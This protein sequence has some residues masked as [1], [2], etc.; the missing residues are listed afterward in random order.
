MNAIATQTALNMVP[1]YGQ[2]VTL[3]E[4]VE[5]EALGYGAWGNEMGEFLASQMERLAQL[6]AGRPP[7]I[8]PISRTGWK[9]TIGNFE[10]VTSRWA[11]MRVLKPAGGNAVAEPASRTETERSSPAGSKDRSAGAIQ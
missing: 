2:P 7:A 11:T 8:R 9:S 5:H 1:T 3:L 4:V 10:T 6:I